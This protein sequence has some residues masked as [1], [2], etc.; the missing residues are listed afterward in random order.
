MIRERERAVAGEEKQ[1][2]SIGDE[3]LNK[4]P[5]EK[6]RDVPENGKQQK[7][8]EEQMTGVKRS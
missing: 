1:S 4:T 3:N 8:R 2:T 7:C 6:E 5:K